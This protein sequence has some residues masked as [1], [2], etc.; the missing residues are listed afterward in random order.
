MQIKHLTTA[1]QVFIVPIRNWNHILIHNLHHLE[2]RFYSTYKELKQQ[3]VHKEERMTACFY[4]TYKELKLKGRRI[5][6]QK[7][8]IVFIVPIRNWN[9][10]CKPAKARKLLSFYSTYKELKHLR[11]NALIIFSIVFIVPIRNWNS[12][13][14]PYLNPS[15]W[16]FIVPIRNWNVSRYPIFSSTRFVF[17][18]PIRNWNLVSELML[19]NN[20]FVFIVPIRNWNRVNKGQMFYVMESFYS[21][22][23]ELKPPYQFVKNYLHIQ[24]L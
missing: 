3:F 16:V 24:F 22:Y 20:S 1:S 6:S 5:Q 15:I 10:P 4:S 23:K 9:M 13:F 14:N 21:T 2:L 17:I 19:L 8:S 7:Y 18:V 12:C 11:I